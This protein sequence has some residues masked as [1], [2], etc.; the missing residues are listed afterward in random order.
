M[1]RVVKPGEFKDIS[2]TEITTEIFSFLLTGS[3]QTVSAY[4]IRL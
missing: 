2:P 1:I 4:C 3:D